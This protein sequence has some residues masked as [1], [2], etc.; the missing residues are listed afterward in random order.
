[1][2]ESKFFDW[3]PVRKQFTWLYAFSGPIA[4]LP[5]AKKVKRGNALVVIPAIYKAIRVQ[6][7]ILPVVDGKV[8]YVEHAN[9][10]ILGVGPQYGVQMSIHESNSP[11][12]GMAIRDDSI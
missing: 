10:S 5:R 3:F 7:D 11:D 8:E 2:L 1:I 6:V 4:E 9:R 12:V